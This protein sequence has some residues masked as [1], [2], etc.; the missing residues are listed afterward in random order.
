MT[1]EIA[2]KSV[3]DFKRSIAVGNTLHCENY[4]FPYLSGPRTVT[5]VQTN[6]IAVTNGERE[7]WWW[8]PKASEM[9]VEG[10]SVSQLE[11]DGTPAFTYTFA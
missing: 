4:R 9:R 8:Y 2:F 11:T 7:I 10:R 1:T 6:A 3:A 5:K